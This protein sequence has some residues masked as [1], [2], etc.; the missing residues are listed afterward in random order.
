MMI[1][2]NTHIPALLE[3]LADPFRRTREEDITTEP[4]IDPADALNVLSFAR[5]RYAI[6]HLAAQDRDNAIPVREIA[7]YIAAEENDCPIEAVTSEERTRVYIS[8]IQQHCTTLEETALVDY[9]D[10]RKELKP[11]VECE[12]VWRAY[13]SFREGLTG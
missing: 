6:E 7:E 9:D 4:T 1:D 10:D 5:R 3:K 8:L 11:T 13:C 2:A 12:R